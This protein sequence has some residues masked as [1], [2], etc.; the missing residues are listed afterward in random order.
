MIVARPDAAGN[1][2]FLGNTGNYPL[3]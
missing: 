2:E 1:P 3:N